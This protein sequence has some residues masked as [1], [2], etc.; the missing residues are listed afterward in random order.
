[1][2]LSNAVCIANNSSDKNSESALYKVRCIV[3]SYYLILSPN[4]S[5]PCLNYI[6]PSPIQKLYV[7]H[8]CRLFSTVNVCT[9]LMYIF[10]VKNKFFFVLSLFVCVNYV[11]ILIC[12][13]YVSTKY[14]CLPFLKII[15][16]F[17]L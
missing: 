15:I 12:L 10:C 1:M 7:L 5:L 2:S 17:Q 4:V 11:S 16:S 9:L 8:V 14:P 3:N 13:M 6:H